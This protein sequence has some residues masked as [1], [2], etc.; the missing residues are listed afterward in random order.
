M[1]RENVTLFY[2]VLDRDPEL[3]ARA[4]GL[5]KTFKDQEEVL[6][7]FLALA[8]EA[9]LPFT[10]EEYLNVQYEKAVLTSPEETI[11]KER[12]R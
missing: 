6:D 7:A 9:G 5:R 3:R 8:E 11:R 2:S 10:L 1:S 12:K 4:L